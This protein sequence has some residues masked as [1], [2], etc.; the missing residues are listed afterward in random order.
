[1]YKRYVIFRSWLL[2]YLTHQLALPILKLIRKPEV[3]PF[4]RKELKAFPPSTLGRELIEMLEE[5]EL[6]LLTHYAKH[7]MKHILLEY[8]TTDKG[9]VS[10][11][12]FMLGNGH[13]SFPVFISVTFGALL[14][15]EHWGSFLHAFK[16]GKSAQ[17]IH[18]WKWNE[19]VH[20]ETAALKQKIFNH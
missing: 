13:V 7:D 4:T 19:I 18:H 5:K 10:L 14:M 6:Q 20:E 17:Q 12:A 3:F 15:P 1:M 9:E 8:P 16:R 11:Q 2:V